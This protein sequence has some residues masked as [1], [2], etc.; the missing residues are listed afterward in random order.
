M[1]MTKELEKIKVNN[2]WLEE[3]ICYLKKN[4]SQENWSELLIK[5]ARHSK[6]SIISK[7]YQ[8]KIKK[9]NYY[10]SDKDIQILQDSYNSKIPIS[11][12]VLLLNNK[13]TIESIYTKAYKLGIKE[14]EAWTDM[15]I[16]ILKKYYNN[17][18]IDEMMI[19]LPNRK[20]ENIIK[21]ASNLG[22]VS[23]VT[24]KDEDKKFI[25]DN[26]LNMTDY[27]L[28][29]E[30]HRTF[31]STKAMREQLGLFRIVPSGVYNSLSEYIRKRNKQWKKDSARNCNFKC[32]LSGE[33]FQAIHHI[34]GMN[35][36]LNETLDLLNIN[37]KN[38]FNDYNQ[39]ELDLILMKFLEVQNTYPLGICLKKEIHKLFHDIYGYGNNIPSQWE[40]F[41]VNYTF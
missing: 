16:E 41:I 28:S 34:Y 12:L 4:Y 26:W 32:S 19:L 27:E 33:R 10:W 20:R 30:L 36:I 40:E 31:R 18:S 9:E 24:W 11:Q 25:I 15:E 22:L 21:F 35:L 13:Y 38:S 6:G 29:E 2:C 14:K 3:E 7:A 17:T 37:V 23:I 39:E 8:L 1:K 5:L